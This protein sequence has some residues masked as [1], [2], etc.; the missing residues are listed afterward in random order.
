M[1]R[2]VIG[3]MGGML[4]T[5]ASSQAEQHAP[6]Q[7]LWGDTH[8]HT[9]WSGDAYLMG[10]TVPPDTAYR[11]ARGETVA[12]SDG[13]QVSIDRPLDFLVVA[14]HARPIFHPSLVGGKNPR[15]RQVC[16]NADRFN[17][18]GRFTAFSGYEWTPS[19]PRVHRVVIFSDG[20]DKA[21][22][23]P[24]FSAETSSNVEELWSRLQNYENETGGRVLT[25]SHGANQSR[26]TQF[27]LQNYDGKDLDRDYAETRSRWEPLY[28][29]IQTKGDS[30]THPVL[31]PDDTFADYYRW[32]VPQMEANLAAAIASKKKQLKAPDKLKAPNN[33]LKAPNKLK[34]SNQLKAPNNKLKALKTAEYARSALRNGLKLHQALGVNPFKIGLIGSTDMHTG[35]ATV[36]ED[37][38]QGNTASTAPG[39]ER[40]PAAYEK[41]VTK[42]GYYAAAGLAAVWAQ[43]NTRESIF[44]AMQRRE[45]YATTGPRILLQ[46]FAC[47]DYDDIDVLGSNFREQGYA[48]GVPMGGD[49]TN[50]PGPPAL[51]IR[52]ARDP[53]GANL[54]RIQVIKGWLDRNG[55]LHEKIYN[56]AVS[57][58]RVID[59][60]GKVQPVGNTITA[61]GIAYSNRIGDAELTAVW[62]DPDFNKKEFAFYYV[63]VLEIPTPQWPAFDRQR[64]GLKD[65]HSDIPTMAQERAYSSPIWYTP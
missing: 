40:V 18:P 64:Y 59:K 33:K 31:S 34:A 58:N 12:S 19:G 36:G 30:E 49:L 20:A 8:L 24:F 25:I 9:S 17:A 42:G 1:N 15:W 52:A 7:V 4:L 5:V 14:D 41:A 16:A 47:F 35:L 45:V 38:F 46:F 11:F 48:G 26:G 43:E 27:A 2:F 50:A 63:R 57:G 23:L 60:N 21:C 10:T 29:V 22:H 6:T 65:I 61:D 44:A 28:E 54:D 53:N 51:L 13:T 55:Q 39:P 32:P 56:V 37:N 3:L 62:R